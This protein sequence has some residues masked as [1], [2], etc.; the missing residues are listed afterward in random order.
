MGVCKCKKRSED[1][2][3]NHKRF[4]CDSCVV[5]DHPICYIRSYVDWLT[6]CDFEDSVCGVCKGRFDAD[7]TNDSV[8]LGCYHLFHPECIDVY[9]ATLSPNTPPSSYPCPKCPKPILPTNDSNSALSESMRDK[10]SLSSWADPVLGPLRLKKEQ[11]QQ[12]LQQQQQQTNTSLN[13]SGTTSNYNSTLTYHHHSSSGNN[14][15]PPSS[16]ND[17]YSGS[18][19]G[20]GSNSLINPS[21]LEETPPLSH[22][23]TNPYGLASRKH[24]DTVIQ[25]NHQNINNNNNNINQIYDDYD[26]YNKKQVNP[27]SKI[28]TK[29][30]ETKPIYLVMFTIIVILFLYIIM[31]APSTDSNEQPKV[32]QKDTK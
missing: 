30:K 19:S 14:A 8:R 6:D 31:K 1:F 9:V 18:A 7:D 21:L 17:F 24:E 22:L 20:V 32:D 23:N 4:I 26:K 12:Q 5:S 15:S 29:I 3:F 25:L 10:F 2:C 27:I 11:Q 16:T 28:I 13:G